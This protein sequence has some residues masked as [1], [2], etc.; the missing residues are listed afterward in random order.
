MHI[1]P[2][3]S[4][5]HSRVSLS[6]SPPSRNCWLTTQQNQCQFDGRNLWMSNK[7][8]DW[9][10]NARKYRL[11]HLCSHYTRCV[12]VSC[13]SSSLVFPKSYWGS[14]PFK[15][16]GR[17]AFVCSEPGC[18]GVPMC[19][20]GV[21]GPGHIKSHEFHTAAPPQIFVCPK[22]SREAKGTAA[23]YSFMAFRAKENTIRSTGTLLRRHF[24]FRIALNLIAS[25]DLHSGIRTLSISF[26]SSSLVMSVA[27]KPSRTWP[28]QMRVKVTYGKLKSKTRK[29]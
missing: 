5:G 11:A 13:V 21:V 7:A 27:P 10:L 20:E 3:H 2:I 24:R 26:L 6:M 25:W 28:S 9:H 4:S 18:H 16:L 12:F 17:I 23:S 14:F 19:T 22:H 8:F 15:L 1:E 29:V